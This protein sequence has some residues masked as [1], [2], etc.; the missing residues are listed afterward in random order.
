MMRLAAVLALLLS[1]SVSAS[2]ASHPTFTNLPADPAPPGLVRGLHYWISNE[3]TLELFHNA[4]KDKGG[5]YVGVGTDQN[6]LLGA[7]ARAEGLVLLDFDQSVV[8]LHRVYRVIFLAAE[9]P[10][11]FLELWQK[12]SRSEVRRLIQEGYSDKRQRAGALLALNTAR[13]AVERRFGRLMA[14]MAKANQTCFLT[15]AADY[16]HLRRLFQEDKVFMVRGDLT[17]RRTMKALGEALSASGKTVG[18]LYL[19]NAEQ[20]FAYDAQYRNN[21]RGLALTEN[22]VVLRTSGERG[23]PHV[24]GTHYHYNTQSGPNFVAWLDDK[25]TR[26]SVTMLRFA[27]A[28]GQVRG[29]SRLDTPPAEAREAAKQKLLAKRRVK[30]APARTLPARAEN[31][32]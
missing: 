16:A 14:Q 26:K 13:G 3:D 2:E 4:V 18:V 30:R 9:T 22:S 27:A 19:S 32:P 24:K 6:Y 11:A 1:A 25:K 31:L 5:V 23:I 12:Q 29:L 21:I 8:D 17:A 15:N 28:E 7:W 10:G 20:Y